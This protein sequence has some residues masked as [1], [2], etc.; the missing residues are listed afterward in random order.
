MGRVTAYVYPW[1]VLGD[2]EALAR[3]RA[4]GADDLAI[5]AAYHTV[6]AA[7]P[8][9]PRRALVTASHAALYRPVRPEAWAGRALVPAPAPWSGADDAFGA[10]ATAVH[11]AGMRV[12]A[13]VVL[14]H[15]SLLGEHNPELAVSNCFG[16]PYPYA[17][18]PSSPQV[19]EYAATLAAEA[20][21]GLPVT[22]V[23]LEACGQLGIM[24]GG[25]HDK[26][27]GAYSP[28]AQRLLSIC[29]C[30][31]CRA[32]WR[33][34]GLEPSG[35]TATL[36]DRVRDLVTGG[37]RDALP[38]EVLGDEVAATLLATRH[39]AAAELR[40]AVVDGL[41]ASAPHL[42][43][44]L[45]AGPDPWETGALPG[46]PAGAPS[47]VDAVVLP[48]WSPAERTAAAL[49]RASTTIGA[50]VAVGAYVTALPPVDPPDL[51][52]HVDRLLTAGVDELHLYHAGLAGPDRFPLLIDA[53]VTARTRWAAPPP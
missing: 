14:T 10:A 22:G 6:R 1:D 29:C 39:R 37:P 13:W 16:E 5:A 26:T 51:P 34:H 33:A 27:D 28:A 46:L 42:R 9:H 30:R 20:I 35:V 25:H 12:T 23:C 40:H 3:L 48:C 38:A 8:H 36:R 7:T 44:T 43:L 19:R 18:C 17:L 52:P 21:R 32:S 47:D 15:S 31:T 45:H 24:H 2:P 53:A 50:D 41:R 11:D 49:R 4:I